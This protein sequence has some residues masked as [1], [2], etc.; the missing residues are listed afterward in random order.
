V[1]NKGMR[2]YFSKLIYYFYKRKWVLIL[3]TVIGF[4]TIFLF[5]QLALP[6]TYTAVGSMYIGNGNP[7]ATN[8]QYTSTGDLE[9]AQLLIDTYKVVINS[10]VV[11]DGI[12]TRLSS[13]YPSITPKFIIE[14]LSVSAVPNTNVLHVQS[15]TVMPEL[16]A[17]I[18]NAVLDI[19]PGEI[20]RVISAG[21]CEIIDH[22][23][24]P[25]LADSR[26][27]AVRGVLGAIVGF[28]LSFSILLILF[29]LDRSISDVRDLSDYY[30]PPVLASITWEKV[31]EKKAKRTPSSFLLSSSSSMEKMESFAKLRMNMLYMLI[32]KEHQIVVITSPVSGEGKTTNAANLAISC[33]MGGKNTLLIDADMR[34]ACMRDLF[35]YEAEKP[36]LSEI[37]IG[38]AGWR[39]SVLSTQMELLKVLPAGQCPPNP[40]ELLGS[41]KMKD[42]LEELEKEYDLIIID[43]PPINVVADPL[44]LSSEVSGSLLV[45]RQN[46]TDHRDLRNALVSAEMTGMNVLGFIFYGEELTPQAR[47]GRYSKKYYQ[48]YYGDYYNNTPHNTYPEV[49]QSGHVNAVSVSESSSANAMSGSAEKNNTLL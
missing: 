23:T 27:S 3:S 32:G 22:A 26:H 45:T 13:Q 24:I 29:L 40:A 39:E 48:K 36:G 6:D 31:D 42:L 10:D 1:E 37:L 5:S 28:V 21:S 11:M 18:V 20:V 16:S 44:M 2:I 19:A 34:R 46:Y 25:V 17:D 4:A 9:S 14:S 15:T 49:K 35:A 12:T 38:Y 43:V 8:Y 41:E 30:T 7:A 47:Y 33:A